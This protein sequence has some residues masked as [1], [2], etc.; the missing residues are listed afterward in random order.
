MNPDA[1]PTRKTPLKPRWRTWTRGSADKRSA[2]LAVSP[3][4]GRT[5]KSLSRPAA[6]A[7]G[8]SGSVPS[9]RSLWIL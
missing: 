9:K 2:S 5:M 7:S 8:G 4:K 3:P 1:G 6:A